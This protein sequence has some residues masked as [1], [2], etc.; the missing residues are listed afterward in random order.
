MRLHL[1]LMF[2]CLLSSCQSSQQEHAF[3]PESKMQGKQVSVEHRKGNSE[4]QLAGHPIQ[5]YLQHQRIP[6]L[7]KDVYKGT[8]NPNEEYAC[9][10]YM[11]S[12]FSSDKET[13]AFYFLTITKTMALADGA[14]AEVLSLAAKD[15]VVKRTGDF[16]HYFN[17]ETLLTEYDLDQ[18]SANVC[19]ELSLNDDYEQNLNQL[20]YQMKSN[21]LNCD[22]S[23]KK[24]L[25]KFI[26]LLQHYQP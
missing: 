3:N 4:I 19:M 18:W 8:I 20:I 1:Y 22:S 26:Y 12:L 16:L 9:Y 11:D 15:Y 13:Q 6:K 17:H 23:S 2:I 14:Y 7:I 24:V 25:D 10:E 21:A 5:F